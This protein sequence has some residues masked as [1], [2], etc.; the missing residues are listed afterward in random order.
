M[1]IA[2][3]GAGFTGLA[4]AWNAVKNGFDVDV[5]ESNNYPGGLAAGIKDKSWDWSIEHHYHHIFQ[6]DGDAINLLDEMG[7]K[8]DY[9]LRKLILAHIIK[10]RLGQ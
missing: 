7:L 9:F 3:I 8:E 10:I 6:T 1:R 5:F 2:I 4:A